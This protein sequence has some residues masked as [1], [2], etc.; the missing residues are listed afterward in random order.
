MPVPTMEA[1]MVLPVGRNDAA[2]RPERT[3]PAIEVPVIAPLCPPVEGEDG[4]AGDAG[5]LFLPHPPIAIAITSEAGAKSFKRVL[6]Q[7]SMSVRRTR[8]SEERR[9]GEECRSRW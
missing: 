4:A 2:P 9:V 1:V 6:I 5:L 3:V 7:C 8:R